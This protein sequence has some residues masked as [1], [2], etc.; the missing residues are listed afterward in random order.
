ML[1]AVILLLKTSSVTSKIFVSF[2]RLT[3]KFNFF[4]NVMYGRQTSNNEFSISNMCY[5]LV[6]M[7]R[8]FLGGTCTLF[9]N[10]W[11]ADWSN[12][13]NI[14]KI[15]SEDG[16]S[17]RSFAAEDRMKI[18]SQKTLTGF[19][20]YWIGWQVVV[21]GCSARSLKAW[22]LLTLFQ[23][24]ITHDQLASANYVNNYY[25]NL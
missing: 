2:L 20:F 21:K 1:Y 9:Y 3:V 18:S 22:S 12:P 19:R 5:F 23:V 6:S 7:I 17:H 13:R 25:H 10:C 16:L 24:N 11:V 4:G 14:Q 8:R 15:N